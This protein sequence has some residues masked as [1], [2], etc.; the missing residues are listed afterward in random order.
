MGVDSGAVIKALNKTCVNALQAAAGLCLS[1]TNYSVEI[2][3]WLFKLTEVNDTDL[4]RIFRHFEIDSSRLQRDLTRAL[5]RLKT[6]NARTP[7]LSPSI[8]QLVRS[9][10][11]YATLQ[12]KAPLVR[13]G[14][15]LLA[16]LEDEQLGR[17]ARDASTEFS[18]IKLETL[19]SGM[20]SLIAG[21]IEDEGPSATGPG[22][23]R[24]GA[25]PS[26]TS[27]TPALDQYTIN[28]TARAK[29]GQIDPVLGREDE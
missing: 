18:K 3:H 29:A 4:S 8:D 19:S 11:V 28:L 24:G 14:H 10:W 15:L 9:A 20:A 22:E 12:Y 1:R 6:G 16:L 7:S 17:L 23:T 2:E 27:Q 5:D 25:T 26:A 21:T 13:S